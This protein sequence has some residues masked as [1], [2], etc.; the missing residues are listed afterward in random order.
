MIRELLLVEY[1]YM[2]TADVRALLDKACMLCIL[3]VLG[4]G[5][6][7][8]A[9]RSIPDICGCFRSSKVAMDARVYIY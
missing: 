2:L 8:K 6:G 7:C 9:Q 4:K 3:A 1:V 5:V